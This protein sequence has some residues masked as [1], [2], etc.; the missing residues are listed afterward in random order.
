MKSVFLIALLALFPACVKISDENSSSP[1]QVAQFQPEAGAS[2]AQ[3]IY[4]QA[5][6]EALTE[7]YKYKVL[8]P[9]PTGA[10][11][12]QRSLR[13]GD[14]D[15]ILLP[16]VLKDG[17]FTDESP[18]SGRDYVYELGSI[19]DGN[20]QVLVSYTAHVPKDSVIE[21]SIELSAD[22]VWNQFDGRVFLT[23]QASITTNGFSFS[24]ETGSLISDL[25]TIRSYRAGSMA[26]QGNP[27]RTGGSVRILARTASGKL[28]ME[29][30]GQN[31]G[32]GMPGKDWEKFGDGQQAP[33]GPVNGM[34]PG[35]I[36]KRGGDGYRG[37][38]SG[39]FEIKLKD[40][41]S[42][43]IFRTIETGIGGFGGPG[44]KGSPRIEA[45]NILEGPRGEEG[46][47][48]ADGDRESSYLVDPS[49]RI[50]Y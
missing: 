37:G 39:N 22:T 25:G 3:P 6:V 14:S 10:Q 50:S 47:P 2:K 27:G 18:V 30:R 8:F 29:M 38:N 42:L 4:P 33:G 45:V 1:A 13:S 31:G 17:V 43:T 16:I 48:G 32:L 44:G 23:P 26:P 9:V 36:G 19:E 35:E 34:A 11:V 24:I 41:H 21:S 7:P 49:G 5:A 12:V 15:P 40:A 46:R 28:T 20:F